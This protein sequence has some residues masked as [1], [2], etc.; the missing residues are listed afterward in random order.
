MSHIVEK[1]EKYKGTYHVFDVD[2]KGTGPRVA[3]FY[4][5]TAKENKAKA[6]AFAD[7][8][9][10][11]LSWS[12]FIKQPIIHQG[13]GWQKREVEHADELVTLVKS[14]QTIIGQL[15][16]PRTVDFNGCSHSYVNEKIDLL[17]GD[18][19]WMKKRVNQLYGVQKRARK[20]AK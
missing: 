11:K 15:E 12:D 19:E 17:I 14:F 6:Q 7:A 10:K 1:S 2:D 9:N 13:P 4:E 3:T 16:I 5:G 18:L 20:A 8:H